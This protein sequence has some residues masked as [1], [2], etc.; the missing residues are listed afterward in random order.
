MVEERT[1]QLHE[2]LQTLMKLPGVVESA[3]VRDLLALS[4]PAEAAIR[5]AREEAASN[6]EARQQ[7]MSELSRELSLSSSYAR[8]QRLAKDR[9]GSTNITTLLASP[10]ECLL[11]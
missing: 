3:A 8:A 6:D 1:H 2:Y 11:L 4:A 10:F 9:A 5:K 7:Q